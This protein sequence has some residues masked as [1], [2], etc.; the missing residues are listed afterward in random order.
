MKKVLLLLAVAGLF[1]VA[2]CN[3]P[4]ESTEENT[5]AITDQT[6]AEKLEAE[7]VAA[8]QEM[9]ATDTNAMMEEDHSGNDHGEGGH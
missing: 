2:A 9:M 7:R 8:E 1:T 3:K 6:E 4:A 5:E